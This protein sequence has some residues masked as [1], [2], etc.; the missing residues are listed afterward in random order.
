M[1]SPEETA[2]IDLDAVIRSGD[3]DR[4]V[5]ALDTIGR[6]GA[7]LAEIGRIMELAKETRS[8]V[9]RNAAAIAL[10]DLNADGADQLLIDLINRKE[11]RG[12]NGTLLYALREMD[13]FVPLSALLNLITDDHSYEALEGTLDI[14]ANNAERYTEE[15]KREAIVLLKLLLTSTDAH[16]AH[17]AKLA[18]K[19]LTRK[20]AP[21][22]RRR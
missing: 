13:A 9:V 20:A 14:I 1:R 18:I 4:I 19:Y 21:R 16:T 2:Q 3:D 11:T 8:P 6:G 5:S 7:S 17:F 15:E 12:V 10:V 22:Q